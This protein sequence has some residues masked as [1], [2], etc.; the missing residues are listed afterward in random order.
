[1][2]PPPPPKPIQASANSSEEVPHRR[3]MTLLDDFT[4]ALG[5]WC[6]ETGL[7]K[8]KYTAL[9]EVLGMIQDLV[10][11]K[12]LPQSLNT[13]KRYTSAQLPLMAMRRS[14]IALVPE[15]VPTMSTSHD[16]LGTPMIPMDWLYFFDPIKLFQTV[17]SCQELRNKMH[18]G[19][20]EFVDAPSELWQSHAWGSSIRSCSGDFAHYSN[21]EVIFPSDFMYYRCTHSDCTCQSEQCV[22]LGRVLAVGRDKSSTAIVPNALTLKV[23][24]TLIPAHIPVSFLPPD[25]GFRENELVLVEDG[26]DYILERMICSREPSI[27]LDYEY[28]SVVQSGHRRY[29]ATS[30]RF[31]IKNIL[32]YSTNTIRPFNFSA[33]LR[34][35][36]EIATYG[37]E[38]L[39]E[40]FKHGRSLSLPFLCFID[41]FGLYRNMYRTLMG[42]YLIIAALK[43]KERSR[44]SNV[45][46]ITLGPHGSKFADVID[47]MVGLR[48]LDRGLTL[49]I[50]G[51]DTFVCAYTMAFIGDM[52]QQ[53]ENSSMKSQRATRGCR[54]CLVT[55]SEQTDLQFDIVNKSRYHNETMLLRN[56]V[57]SMATKRNKSK[58]THVCQDWGLKETQSPLVKIAPALDIIRS[59]PPDLAH[60]EYSGMSK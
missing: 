2:S 59:R 14:K 35:E 20:A 52:P 50:N 24:H 39:M 55:N 28:Q 34:I 31:I 53:Q 42:V 22:H 17:L 48:E 11:I 5:L 30:Y 4:F 3:A 12:R 51:E 10:E 27:Y 40:S 37:R 25:D 44:R 23:Q 58:L 26:S 43:Y 19:M 8:R 47:A 60:S 9:L 6:A 57:D 41:G 36:L 1:M 18:F 16:I 46:P 54:Y 29:N 13:L 15:K 7:S 21:G 56:H 38:S 45:L 32:N 49:N 33:P